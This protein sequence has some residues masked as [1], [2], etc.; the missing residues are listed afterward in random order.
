MDVCRISIPNCLSVKQTLSSFTSKLKDNFSKKH[1]LL[2]ILNLHVFSQWICGLSGKYTRSS[3][4]SLANLHLHQYR[5]RPESS[6]PKLWCNMEMPILKWNLNSILL[7]RKNNSQFM[8]RPDDQGETIKVLSL[9]YQ[10]DLLER[11]K[12]AYFSS[13]ER[14][15]KFFSLES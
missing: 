3:V 12:R 7:K 15:N 2:G 1:N 9:L 8:Q 6:L 10:I 14:R 11:S 5:L 4:L 13:R